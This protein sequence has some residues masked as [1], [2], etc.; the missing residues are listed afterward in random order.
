MLPED[1]RHFTSGFKGFAISSRIGTMPSGLRSSRLSGIVC[2]SGTVLTHSRETR[3]GV[4]PGRSF[5]SP[6][7]SRGRSADPEIL[8]KEGSYRFS[9]SPVIAGRRRIEAKNT[10]T[11]R[12]AYP[13]DYIWGILPTQCERHESARCP[14]SVIFTCASHA[15]WDAALALSATSPFGP[16]VG[17]RTC[18]RPRALMRPCGRGQTPGRPGRGRDMSPKRAKISDA[19]TPGTATA[20]STKYFRINKFVVCVRHPT[21]PLGSRVVRIAVSGCD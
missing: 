21:L 11:I 6:A 4:I 14:A 5:R 19:L 7:R 18:D 1:I 15:P 2:V 20:N 17:A 9:A 16:C 3:L 13:C 8:A 10:Q 12:D